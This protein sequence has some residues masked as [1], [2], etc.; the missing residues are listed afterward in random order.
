M[1]G[2]LEAEKA[3][4]DYV[5]AQACRFRT[6]QFLIDVQ[7]QRFAAASLDE[8][9]MHVHDL[10]VSCFGAILPHT[11]VRAVGINFAVHFNVGDFEVRDRLGTMLA[12]KEPWGEWGR[13]INQLGAESNESRGGLLTL[14]MHGA[15]PDGLRGYI[16]TKVEPS[17]EIPLTGV[18]MEVNDH[19][20]L[21]DAQ[22]KA[23]PGSEAAAL[24]QKQ[25]ES[26]LAHS[27]MIVSQIMGLAETCR[28]KP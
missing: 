11:P 1:I 3:Q 10:V 12:P 4:V 24:V 28:D 9:H 25:W 17:T 21:A 6:D 7:E 16:R 15:R 20:A 22:D 8:Q 27:N 19:Y 23:R 13:E 14:T 5:L 26:S 18:H 2:Q